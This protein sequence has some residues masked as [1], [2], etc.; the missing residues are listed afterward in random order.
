[1]YPDELEPRYQD[2]KQIL[3]AAYS[4]DEEQF[5]NLVKAGAPLI[6]KNDPI[7]NTTFEWA[8]LKGNKSIF[9]II[10]ASGVK[11]P[12]YVYANSLKLAAQE[13]D[14]EI[15]KLLLNTNYTKEINNGDLQVILYSTVSANSDSSSIAIDMLLKYFD[16]D[17]NFRV[18]DYG[19]TLLMVAAQNN[20]ADIVKY[21]LDHGADRTL[22]IQSGET[23]LYFA[24]NEHIREL[25]RE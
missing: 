18:G 13:D 12:D 3:N 16:L 8:C 24:R 1:M 19:H 23:V 14:L 11:F 5:V 7:S 22:T 10:E 6:W 21:L 2:Y 17:V 4:N 9:E 25:L 15:L 20:K